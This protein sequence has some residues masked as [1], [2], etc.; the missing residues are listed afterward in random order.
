MKKKTVVLSAVLVV[1]SL[2]AAAVIG[3]AGDEDDLL[4]RGDRNLQ[5]AMT[6]EPEFRGLTD[7]PLEVVP[8]ER[9]ET[10]EA[11]PALPSAPPPVPTS[12]VVA[13]DVATTDVADP[14]ADAEPLTT[15]EPAPT[16]GSR[17]ETETVTIPEATTLDLRLDQKLTTQYNRP[18]DPFTATLESPIMDGDRV[19]LPAGAKLRGEVKQVQQPTRGRPGI[20]R[21]AFDEISIDGRSFPIEA[22]ITTSEVQRTVIESVESDTSDPRAGSPTGESPGSRIG[23]G[24]LNGALLGSILGGN[25]R[26]T[27]IGAAAGAVLGAT[28]GSGGSAGSS[29][30]GGGP[31]GTGV[32]VALILAAGS[33]IVCVLDQSLV[34]QRSTL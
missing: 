17:M 5:L 11:P 23:R 19:L 21:V 3:L 28:G 34:F 27:L 8:E 25:S 29:G 24:A 4:V 33:R 1:A 30:S 22:T 32:G 12:T 31:L 26:G 20:L 6:S 2:L 9:E 18:G 15:A 7:V 16:A 13:P 14:A 10:P